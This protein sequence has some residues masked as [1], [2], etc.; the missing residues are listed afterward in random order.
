MNVIKNP[1]P[2]D[3][4]IQEA[5]NETSHPWTAL[6]NK[7]LS[8]LTSVFSFLLRSTSTCG[9]CGNTC[10][11][12]QAV[13]SLSLPLPIHN[14]MIISVIL[15]PP[16]LL[17]SSLLLAPSPQQ[18]SLQVRKNIVIRE[19]QEL[20]SLVD[21][22]HLPSSFY[23]IQTSTKDSSLTQDWVNGMLFEGKNLICRVLPPT[24]CNR[25]SMEWL[26]NQKEVIESND[27][28]SDKGSQ[29]ICLR[30]RNEFH[31]TTLVY[32]PTTTRRQTKAI[33]TNDDS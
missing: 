26:Q 30:C 18:F 24:A 14:L 16:L 11:S 9:S 17:T 22:L 29:G 13:T 28:V 8:P 33:T 4:S 1:P 21:I 2:S 10:S 15:Y 19:L 3:T 27:I 6:C 7:E 23:S 20:I 32:C 25:L 5:L 31:Y 12:Y